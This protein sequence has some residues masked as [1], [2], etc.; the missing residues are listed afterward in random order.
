V[1]S[2]GGEIV[3]TGDRFPNRR[4]G[5]QCRGCLRQGWQ[6]QKRTLSLANPRRHLKRSAA[7]TVQN[8][9]PSEQE[10]TVARFTTSGKPRIIKLKIH[11][12]GKQ[13]FSASGERLEAIHYVIHTDIGG[14]AGAFAPVIGKQLVR[15]SRL[16][17]W[18]KSSYLREIHR[19]A[20]RWRPGPEYRTCHGAV[21]RQFLGTAV[22]RLNNCFLLGEPIFEAKFVGSRSQIDL[23]AR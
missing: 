15:Y 12:D 9:P 21:G 22:M 11:A 8:I 17:R 10:T 1:V 14:I 4:R 6:T 13:P 23:T 2:L 18:R 19:S 20:I 3:F 7:D 16:D 5:Q